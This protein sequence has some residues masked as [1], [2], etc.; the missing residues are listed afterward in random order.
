MP[1]HGVV[2]ANP[3]ALRWFLPMASELAKAGLLRIYCTPIASG[4][5][6]ERRLEALPG[7]LARLARRQL[8]LRPVPDHITEEQVQIAGLISH[9]AVVALAR[10]V[11]SPQLV[12]GANVLA[13]ASF[14]RATART[15]RSGDL[16]IIASTG[17]ALAS[18]TRA[19]ELGVPTFLDYPIAHHRF[20]DELLREE[21][22]LNPA[23]APTLQLQGLS[24]RASD[25]LESEI[26]L[27][28]RVFV[29]SSFSLTTFLSAGVPEEKL[30]L[31]PFG[32]D[33][34]MFSPNESAPA[35]SEGRPF[36]I[37]FAGQVTQ[38][39]GISYLVDAFAQANIPRAELVFLGRPVGPARTLLER[40]G[41]SFWPPVPIGELARLYH[42]CDVF[43]LPSLVEGF[44]QTAAIAMAC[45]LPVILSEN[46]SGRDVIDDGVSGYIVPVRDSG[47]IAGRLRTL[48]EDP[49]ARASMGQAGRE[50]IRQFTWERYGARVISA[51]LEQRR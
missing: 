44:P 20:S 19:R 13:K 41:V 40:P 1:N 51:V 36:R 7:S 11:T 48:Y 4:Q 47:A 34:E 27:A 24:P 18:F 5:Q 14:D 31:T 22:A 35:R 25:R 43:V 15:L 2:V 10:T 45:G 23:F 16:G 28:D 38:R 9:L 26:E 29:N 32:V 3:G 39:K 12:L 6:V 37:L 8:S 42:E 33:V 21:A 46:T 49:A 50:R 30:A 17:A